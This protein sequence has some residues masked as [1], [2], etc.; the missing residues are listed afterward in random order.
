MSRADDVRDGWL[1][2]GMD[3]CPSHEIATTALRKL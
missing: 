2:L 1:M 3:I